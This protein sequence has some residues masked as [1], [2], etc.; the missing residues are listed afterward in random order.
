MNNRYH[1]LFQPFTFPS[2]LRLTNRILM[3][4]M[5][6]WSG[7]QEDTVSNAEFAYYH[8]RAAGLGAVITACGYVMPEGKGFAGQFGVH[9][10]DLIPNLK[11]LATTIQAQGALAILQIYHGGRLCPPEI[12][13]DKQPVSASF[14]PPAIEAAPVPRALT[15]AEIIKTIQAFGQ[16]TRRAI[17]A[18]FDGVEIHGANGYLLQQ[19]FSPH[20]N[21]RTDRWGGS[22]EK[23]L[24]LP[25]AVVDEVINTVT[26][27]ASRPFLVGY[28][29]SPEEI[30][31]PG[32][33]ME[34]T[35]ELVNLLAHKKLDYLHVSTMS[36][37]GGSLRNQQDKGARAVIIQKQVGHLLPVIGVGSIH[38]ADEALQAFETGVPLIALGRELL[39]EPDWISKIQNGQEHQI[40]TTLSKKA[41]QELL[42]P[43]GLW[44]VLMNSPGWLPVVE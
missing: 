1:S 36:F 32:I 39:M 15:E 6:T 28:R 19:F 8:R 31:E 23:R 16:A 27:Q 4:P 34:D 24:A 20:A 22:L 18:G 2:G 17:K 44:Q 14:I 35:L 3:A 13:P 37:W 33:T 11:Q 10:D 41:Q 7:N 9:Q 40:R 5:T 29:F 25:L 43:D 21:R 38:T 30:E 42:L 26:Q 12:L